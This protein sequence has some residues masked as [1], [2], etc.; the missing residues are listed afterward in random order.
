MLR[1][2]FTILRIARQNAPAKLVLSCWH[3]STNIAAPPSYE[4]KEVR[5]S[6]RPKIS[7]DFHRDSVKINTCLSKSKHFLSLKKFSEIIYLV[8]KEILGHHRCVSSNGE[9]P[10]VFSRAYLRSQVQ[11]PA[12]QA[13]GC[14]AVH[15][16]GKALSLD[17][18]LWDIILIIRHASEN[19]SKNT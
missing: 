16:T 7:T 17:A 18:Y 3:N 15:R 14:Y 2:D 19:R 9:S 8:P 11:S 4:G 12:H 13:V 5:A 1:Q 6:V 10:C